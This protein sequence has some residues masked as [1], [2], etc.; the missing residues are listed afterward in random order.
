MQKNSLGAVSLLAVLALAGACAGPNGFPTE[1]FA[2]T[3]TGG[4]A[5]GSI[6]GQVTANGTGFAGA[7]VAIA[8]GPSTTTDAT[9]QFRF[10]GLATGSYRLSVLVPAGYVLAPGDSSTVTATV[11]RGQ[12]SVVNWRLQTSVGG[13]GG[14][15]TGAGTGTTGTTGG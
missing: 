9:G 6:S 2:A 15:G 11:A 5:T 1:P 12:T 4:N 10:T 7:A 3:G 13:T 8:N 14:T